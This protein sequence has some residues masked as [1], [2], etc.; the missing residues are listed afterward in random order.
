MA[1]NRAQISIPVLPKEAVDVPELGGEIIVSGLPLSKRL[2]LYAGQSRGDWLNVSRLLEACVLDPEGVPLMSVAEW[3]AFGAQ[4]FEAALRLV[5]VSQRLSGLDA[6]EA[7][8]N[9]PSG[10]S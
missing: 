4:H 1:L 5:Q 3:E 6:E 2:E 7:G 9:L 10:P 8:K